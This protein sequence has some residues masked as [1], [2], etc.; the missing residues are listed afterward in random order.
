VVAAHRTMPPFVSADEVLAGRDELALADVRWSLDGSEGRAE[1]LAATIPDAVFVDLDADLAAPPSPEGG[2]HPLPEPEAFAAALGR[3]GLGDDDRVVAFDQGPGTVAARLVWM[4]RAIG[5]PAAVLDGGLSAW[6]E[7]LAPGGA[8]RPP[9][10]R[11]VVPWPEERLADTDLV[12]HLV[13]EDAAVLLDA[14]EPARYRGEHEPV[15]PRPGHVPGA[16]NLPTS[17]L[18]RDGRLAPPDEL[19]RRFDA[20][21]IPDAK[22]VVASCGSGVTACFD[23]LALEQLGVEHVRLY[24]GSW[25]AWSADPRR[26]AATGPEPWPA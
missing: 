4:L 11:T 3:L 15:D 9:R 13:A 2:R 12:A 8:R 10:T 24:P 5:R 19:G 18:V 20:V 6:P 26:P 7:P 21:G 23:A 25:S 14:R 22:E 1:H 17:A 16:V